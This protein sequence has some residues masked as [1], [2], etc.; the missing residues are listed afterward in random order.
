MAVATCANSAWVREIIC[1]FFI[2]PV[3]VRSSAARTPM[4]AMT[5]RSST[6]VNARWD[7]F[8]LQENFFILFISS[9]A[10]FVFHPFAQPLFDHALI[11]Q[12]PGT[13]QPLDARQHS[14]INAQRNGN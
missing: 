11:I 3:M 14:R 5:T 12:E 9:L 13:G 2:A 8:R 7:A 10:Q 6:R 4:M 1:F